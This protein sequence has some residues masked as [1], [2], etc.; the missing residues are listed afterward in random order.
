MTKDAVLHRSTRQATA[1]SGLLTF[2]VYAKAGTLDILHLDLEEGG[3]QDPRAWFNLSTGAISFQQGGIIAAEMQ[4]AGNG[5][6][7]CSITGDLA[8]AV[9]PRIYQSSDP[10]GFTTDAGTIYIQ[11]AKLEEGYYASGY[12][13]TT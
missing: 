10:A 1:Q 6:Y 11:D 2:S 4:D 9:E 12:I 7:R 3:A 13:E 5:W 8:T